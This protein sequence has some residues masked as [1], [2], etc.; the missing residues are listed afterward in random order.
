MNTI[1]GNLFVGDMTPIW[2]GVLDNQVG[3]NVVLFNVHITDGLPPND[4][5]SP[6]IFVASNTI[7]WN[8][9]CVGLAPAVS[10]GFTF[11]VNTVGGL[12]IGQCPLT[13]DIPVP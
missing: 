5:P 3:G 2:I 6:T 12:D 11:E 8:L 1:D 9:V 7:G 4:D 10:G 13:G